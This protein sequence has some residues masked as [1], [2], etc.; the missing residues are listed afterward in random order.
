M[1]EFVDGFE[2]LRKYGIAATFFGS[3]RSCPG[4]EYYKAAEELGARL[5]K[6]KFAIITGGGPGI[7]E[8]A[9]VGA[10]KVGGKSVGLNIKL[11]IEQK[12]NPYVT[13]SENFHFF[14]SRKVM[15]SFASEVYIY[16]PGGFGTMDEFFEIITLI[17]T[18]KISRIPVVLYGKDYW[19]PLMEFFTK[20]LLKEYKTIDKE[21]L[22]L[23]HVVDS[24]DEAYKYIMK[25]VDGNS[26]Q[27]I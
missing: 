2:I 21:D 23:I 4:D 1:S 16:F 5:A 24:V 14:F 17:Q 22:D 6:A 3:A 19:A 27:Q 25:N 8:A 7:M 9:N 15:L 10:F 12:L 18:K 13:E 26:P 20:S 11:P